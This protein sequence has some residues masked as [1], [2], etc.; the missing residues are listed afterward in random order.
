MSREPHIR[1][2]GPE[3]AQKAHD[4]PIE[5]EELETGFEVGDEL[6]PFEDFIEDEAFDDRNYGLARSRFGWLVPVLAITGVAVWTGFYIWALRVELLSVSSTPQQWTRWIVDWSVPVL[7]IGIAWLIAMRNS[8]REARRFADTAAM[9]STESAELETRLGVVNRE[10]SLA[11]EFLSSQSLELESLGRIASERIATHADELQQLIKNNGKQVDKIGSASETALVNMNK[12][13]DDLPVIATS[14]RDV[15]NQVGNAGRTS[16]DQLEKLIAGFERLNQ[17]GQA[18]ENQVRG[19]SN[20]IEK[21]LAG[22][23]TQ[24]EVIEEQTAARFA[25]LN[26]QTDLYRTELDNREVGALAAMRKRADDLRE[27]LSELDG[28]FSEQEEKSL[29]A[30]QAR[31]ALLRGE[32]ET[33]AQSLREA[34]ADSMEALRTSKERLRDEISEVIATLDE[35]DKKA[36][37]SAKARIEGLNA[38]ATRFD[39]QLT[40]RDLAF[41]EKVSKRQDDFDTREAQSTEILSQRLAEIDEALA[42]R[43]EAQI[44]ETEKLVSHGQEMTEKLDK[45]S[46]LFGSISE[47]GDVARETLD[48]GLS[49]LGEQLAGNRTELAE[50]EA[51]IATLT[52]GGLRLL[53]MIQSGARHAREDFV[54]AVENSAEKLSTVEQRTFMLSS[55]MDEAS[56]RSLVLSGQIEQTQASIEKTD[57]SIDALQAKLA[58]QTE[59]TLAKLQGLRGNLAKLS[60]ETE[61]L[62][63]EAQDRL[64]GAIGELEVA[65]KSAFSAIEDGANGRMAALAET[66]GEQAVEVLD[67]SLRSESAEV[68]GR[69]EQAAAHASGVGREAATQLR[70]Q[71]VKV[72]EL[73]GNLERRV[74]RARELAEEQVDND[75]ARRMALITDSLNSSAIDITTALSTEV[76]DTAWEAYLKG[77]RG[78]FTRR[79]VRLIDNGEAREIAN[80]YQSDEVFRGNVSRYIHDFEAMLRSMLSTRDGNALSVTV[81][82]SDMG[83]LYV[84]LAQAIERLRN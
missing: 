21:T 63:G 16:N 69:L 3:A 13:R 38:E 30:V 84:V 77:D 24:L 73:T 52:D 43:R 45:L 66:V 14:A 44:A 42:E 59:D 15:S 25:A 36:I 41:T 47:Q 49:T 55:K 35:L 17:F 37:G 2:V 12:L 79:A 20:K 54:Q 22:F 68:I 26:E 58:E 64:R 53:E 18:S 10:L 82:G 19:L 29:N 34:E 5:G 80:L 78:I 8:N 62:S 70:D 7:L 4:Q 71:L 50:T 40:Q 76:T 72:N 48:Q 11:R 74:T 83:K 60:N 56:E 31:I 57:T 75:F 33:L 1:A 28:E 81:L 61:A 27:G 6:N 39:E 65:A 51:Q 9:L 46:A 67:K 32:G 23:E